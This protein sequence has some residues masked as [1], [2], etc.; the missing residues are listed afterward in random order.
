MLLRKIKLKNFRQYY[1]E[2]VINFATDS[3]K[4]VTVIHAE[5]GVG[6]TALLNAIKWC[7]YGEFTSNFRNK[8]ALINF[9]A[10]KEGVTKCSVEIEFENGGDEFL[11]SRVFDANQ[12]QSKGYLSGILRVFKYTDGTLGSNLPDPDLVVNGMLPKEMADYFFFQGEGSNAVEAGNKGINLAKSIRNILGFAI[13]E[14]VSESL[15]K[16]LLTINRRIAELDTTGEASRLAEEVE[17]LSNNREELDREIVQIENRIPDLQADYKSVDDELL[18]INNQD[19]QSLKKEE[20]S[21]FAELNKLQLDFKNAKL[22]KTK[23]IHKY[24]WA[25][26][27]KEFAVE[28]LDF[29][30]E[31]TWK[32]R[33]PEP[34]NETFINDILSAAKCICGQ[35]LEVGSESYKNIA[36]LLEK[37]SNPVLQN[38]YGGIR[39]QIQNIR[40]ISSL[41]G[42]AINNILQNNSSLEER[43]QKTKNRLDFIQE[44]ITL[45]PEDKIAELQ[46]KKNSLYRDLT[47]QNQKLGG[48]KNRLETVDKELESKQRRLSAIRPNNSMLNDLA[49]HRRFLED[50]KD[51]LSK[52][53][54]GTEEK[55]RLHI[56]DKVNSMMKSFSRHAYEIRATPGDFSIQ[57][58]TSDGKSVGQGDGLNLLLNL[59]ITAALI[60]FV[61]ENQKV[62]D[63]L[64]AS[65][66]VAPL[67]IDAPFGVLDDS[68]RN[69]VVSSLPQHAEQVMFFVSSSQWKEEMDSVIKPRVGAEYCL[70]LESRSPQ[71]DKPLDVFK[72]NGREIVAN[73]YDRERDRVYAVEVS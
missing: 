62:R 34:Y 51:Y 52:H 49:L 38:R 23:A 41:A 67:V 55:I 45:I 1:A 14:G 57:L 48:M 25:V 12:Q 15:R 19:L 46:K 24:G 71:G 33:L 17:R 47:A 37:A 73:K 42:E 50:L 2:V 27:G 4:N 10:E 35:S 58:V 65:A 56:V 66:T 18:Q 3:F 6:K 29:I 64:L 69:V 43:I 60:E 30:D 61:K 54:H 16:Q 39:A 26:F 36:R 22:E 44:K 68:Y 72:I 32:G 13:A 63:P 11:I 20:S 8:T 70:I 31:S 28:S 21:L 9:E 7:F 40:T 59:S 5:N 53:L